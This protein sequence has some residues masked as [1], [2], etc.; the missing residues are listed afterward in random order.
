ME[1]TWLGGT[2][3]HHLG[4]AAAAL[5]LKLTDDEAAALEKP[6]TNQGPSW[7]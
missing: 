2:K 3:P 7:F 6:F 5:D 4:E 1:Y